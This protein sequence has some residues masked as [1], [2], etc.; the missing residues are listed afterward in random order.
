MNIAQPA[1]KV[2]VIE[3]SSGARLLRWAVDARELVAS[4]EYMYERDLEADGATDVTEDDGDDS[5]NG[6]LP[7]IRA[8]PT[9]I[10]SLP[11]DVVIA[12]QARDTRK[13]ATAI[14][15][16]RL[17]PKAPEGDVTGDSQPGDTD[18]E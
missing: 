14:Y 18:P 15:E 10:Q 8:L 7:G 4:G 16:R 12:M 11:D 17:A 6:E 1:T 2:A 3:K 13:S 5:S 9:F